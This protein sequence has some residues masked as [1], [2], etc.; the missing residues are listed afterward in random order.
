LQQGSL[1]FVSEPVG[2]VLEGQL[3]QQL[4]PQHL[5]QHWKAS[6]QGLTAADR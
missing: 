2:S 4:H 5:L 1:L 6:Q 3:G